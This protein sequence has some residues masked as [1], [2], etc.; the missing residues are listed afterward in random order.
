M[1]SFYVFDVIHRKL[2][3]NEVTCSAVIFA[4]AAVCAVALYVLNIFFDSVLLSL[5]LMAVIVGCMHGINLMLITV[6]P[7]RMIRSGKVSTWSGIL[8]SCTYIGASLSMY[9][10]AA[11]ANSKGWNFTILMWGVVAFLGTAVCTLGAFGWKRF[12]REFSDK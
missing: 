1:L 12:K 5:L 6:V 4:L 10:F 8:N 11:M 9:G 7:K 3:K 2:F